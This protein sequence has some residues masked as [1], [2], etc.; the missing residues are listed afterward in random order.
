MA[1][2]LE[3]AHEL[4]EEDHLARG[5]HQA[6]HGLRAVAAVAEVRL[7]AAEEEGVVAALLQL[8]DDVQ[9]RH[10]RPALRPLRSPQHVS[11]PCSSITTWI[12]PGKF[13]TSQLLK[14]YMISGAMGAGS[15]LCQ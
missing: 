5:D 13:W 6:V 8:R 4:V 11:S 14:S 10:L 3:A 15:L 9:Q 7:G 12:K 2:L 1:G